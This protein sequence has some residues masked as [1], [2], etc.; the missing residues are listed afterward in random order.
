MTRTKPTLMVRPNESAMVPNFE[1][2]RSNMRRFIGWR[3]DASQSGFIRDPEPVQVP[4]RKEYLDALKAGD[5]IPADEA[6]ARI[7]GIN[8]PSQS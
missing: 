5:L 1:L 3:F 6:T 2:V 7:A 8:L 4:Y